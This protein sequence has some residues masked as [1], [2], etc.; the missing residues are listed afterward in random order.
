[1]A[2]FAKLLQKRIEGLPDEKNIHY[3]NMIEVRLKG[4]GCS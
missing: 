4:W 2:G 1:M 3:T